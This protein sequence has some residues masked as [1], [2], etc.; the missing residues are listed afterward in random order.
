MNDEDNT[1]EMEMRKSTAP[2]P[3][4]VE[5]L[6][7]YIKT[8]ID[9]EHDYGTCVYAMSLS[10]T[11][12]FNYVAH[13]LGVTGFQ[14]S[15]A[16]LD[17]IRRTRRLDCPFMIVQGNDMLYPQYD[18]HAKVNECLDNWR[19]WAAEAARKMLERDDLDGCHPDVVAHWHKLAAYVKP[20]SE[21]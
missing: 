5:E 17:I 3:E 13:E 6:S 18:I 15:C 19:E 16:D 8:L 12:T 10:A 2:T 21:N 20:E 7:E 4:T 14:A 11:A 9:M 1:K